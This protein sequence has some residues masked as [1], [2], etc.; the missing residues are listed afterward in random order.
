MTCGFCNKKGH[1]EAHCYIKK[2]ARKS[3]TPKEKVQIDA[4]M[5]IPY[6]YLSWTACY[7]DL[8]LVYKSSKEGLG[9]YLKRSRARKSYEIVRIDTLNFH[10]RPHP[11]D[12]DCN[13]CNNDETND[14]EHES[15]TTRNTTWRDVYECDNCQSRNPD[16]ICA[17]CPECGSMEGY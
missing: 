10:E 9:Y 1:D 14:L 17:G 3:E 12:F 5:E 16:H 2:N 11:Q 6:D 8:C 4:I 15:L 13:S 7:N